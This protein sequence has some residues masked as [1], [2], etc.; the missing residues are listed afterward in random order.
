[1]ASGVSKLPHNRLKPQNWIPQ[2]S[3]MDRYLANELVFPFL[4]GVGA[5]SSLGVSVGALFDLIRR[6]AEYGLPLETALEILLLKIPEFISYAFPMSVLLATLMTYSRLSS[7]S[8][9]TALKGCGI[10][11]YRMIIPAVILSFAVTGLAFTFN[12]LIVPAAN[13][14]ASTTLERAL[15]QDRWP[16]FQEENILYQEYQEIQGDG[17]DEVLTRLFYASRFDG[18]EMRGLTVLDFT[19]AKL[20]QIISAESAVWNFS[21]KTWD[22]FNGTIYLVSADGSYSNILKFQHQ[23]VQ[24]PRTPLDIASSERQDPNEM[25][26]AES[27]ERVRLL[28]QRGSQSRLR[29]LLI[30]IHE[31]YALPFACVV[32][33]IVGSA[34]GCRL[35]RTG[36]ATSFAISIVIIFSYYLL[37]S[38][39][40]AL[41]HSDV[42]TPIVSA[43]LPN[44][45]GFGMGALLLVRAS[46]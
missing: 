2:I 46:Q 38:I 11:V 35:R 4:F 6:V 36:R 10:S 42:L 14:R 21:D 24:L 8:E 23:Q 45:F 1:M 44:L 5:F 20:N 15:G 19:Q 12:E 18:K 22:F 31:K 40:S 17:R 34:L 41:A 29:R 43:W 16:D 25:N 7:D 3:V 13:Y 9:L 32:F 27:W 33:G 28:R 37:Y 30:T 26:L 39:C